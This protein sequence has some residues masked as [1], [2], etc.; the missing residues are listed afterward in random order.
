M[1]SREANFSLKKMYNVASVENGY[2]YWFA[3]LLNICLELFEWEGLP[4]SLPQ[5]EIELQLILTGHCLIFLDDD[6]NLV[7]TY[8]TLYDFDKYYE[9]TKATYA[10]PVLGSKSNIDVN[11]LGYT[12]SNVLIYNSSLKEN[13]FD[14]NIDNSLLTFIQ[15]YAR[16]LAD[17]ESTINIYAVNNRITNFPIAKNDKVM[18][19]LKKFFNLFTLGEHAIIEDDKIIDGFTAIPLPH[20]KASDTLIDLLDAKDKILEQ[21]FRALGVKFRNS[22]RAQM[23]DEEVESDEQVLL[24]SLYD[25]LKQRLKGCSNIKKVFGHN[26]TVK[27]NPKFDRNN[28]INSYAA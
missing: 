9:P 1:N 11:S 20:S 14:L 16:Q 25:M 21:F 2:R 5:R 24:I 28:Y 15:R 22:K 23:S 10:Q 26:V 3:K 12:D 18:G 17:I 13:V 19:S 27:I 6:S 7:T 8:T 4:E